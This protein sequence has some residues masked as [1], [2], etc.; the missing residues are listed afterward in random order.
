MMDERTLWEVGRT[1]AIF[2][3]PLAIAPALIW[4]ERKICAWIQSRIGPNRVGPFG[5]LQPLADVIKLLFKEDIVPRHVDRFIYIV[6]PLIAFF[7]TMIVFGLIPV[8]KPVDVG[9]GEPL[10]LQAYDFGLGVLVFMALVSVGVYGVAFGA[11]ASNNKYSLL[12][13]LRSAAQ[14][15]SYELI[16]TLTV[17][18]V[19]MATGTLSLH[20]IVQDQAENGWLLWR[21]APFGVLAFLLFF[22]GA[23]A[24]NKRAPFD[25]PE[26]EA[27]L[28]GG[29]HTEYSSMKF[30]MF[31]M[32]EYIAIIGMSALMATLFLGGWS[33]PGVIDPRSATL[34]SGLAS[35]AVFLAKTLAL[36]FVYMWIR[37]TLPRFRY[38]VLMRVSWKRL[39]P[40]AF[41]NVMATGLYWTLTK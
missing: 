22:T 4:L 5:L 29:Y 33:L 28:V 3:L 24:E 30:A 1:L 11:W 32:G 15:I 40:A 27:E 9:L 36:V 21:Y 38:D 10:R 39:V 26:A 18:W 2:A 12:G 31:F 14:M 37:W 13:G 25:L 17:V 8:G 16:L 23:L 6:A 7:P 41:V 35:A 20:E 34:A 19:I